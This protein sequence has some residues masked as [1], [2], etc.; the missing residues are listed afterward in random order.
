VEDR[1]RALGAAAARLI[2]I[3]LPLVAV[4]LTGCGQRAALPVLEAPGPQGNEVHYA[5]DASI[6]PASGRLAAITVLTFQ[7][8]ETAGRVGLLL[9][10]GLE[11][12]EV[13]GPGVRSFRVSTSEIA[14]VWNLI[15]VEL[16][17]Q[18]PGDRAT[19]TVRYAGVP[20]KEGAVGGI[21]RSSVELTLENMWHPLLA[22]FDREMVGVLRVH[23]PEG[24]MVVSSGQPRRADEVHELD[25]AVPLMD[26][27]FYAA[28]GLARWG[29]RRYSVY[30]RVAG[31]TE[32]GAVLEAATA[33]GAFLEA[34][35]GE[36]NPLP[37]VRIVITERTEVAMSRKNFIL[38]PR[39]DPAD[40]EG[41]HQFLC[42]ELTHYWTASPG[43]LSPHHWM[44]ESFAE[45][46]ADLF[47]RDRFGREAFERRVADN[48]R[49]ARG[50]GPVWTPD[51]AERPSY[52]VMYRL[53]PWLLSRL[54]ARI[55]QDPF[56]ELVRR[57]MVLGIR[58][59][60]ELL[61]HV[62][63]VGGSDAEAWFRAELAVRHEGP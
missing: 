14:P 61:R 35:F 49:A 54:E 43:P 9:N 23:L 41:I 25:M 44:A 55:G 12:A 45:Y 59:T 1:Q 7:A 26:V 19:L 31:E 46:A 24:W 63:E 2:R 5:T 57:Y 38:L 52:F 53:G 20:D 56:A 13:S 11:V 42:H 8:A 50:H 3:L 28:P 33:C 16:G 6:D 10:H 15:E 62:A 37:P 32:A 4:L 18:A 27:P 17:D 34:R 21:T 60:E 22:T 58:N 48:E 39:M 47:V 30:S 29:T 36:R 40:R 51:A